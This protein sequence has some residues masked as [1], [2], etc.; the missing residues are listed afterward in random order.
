MKDIAEVAAAFGT[1]SLAIMA[2]IGG[3]FALRQIKEAKNARIA[4]LYVAL[5]DSYTSKEMGNYR[6]YVPKSVCYTGKC[7]TGRQIPLSYPVAPDRALGM[8][9]DGS[10]R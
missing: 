1:V 4:T 7:V 3:I 6:L 5:Y 8:A 9:L 2:L 10:H